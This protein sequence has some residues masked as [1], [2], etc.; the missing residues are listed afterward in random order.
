MSKDETENRLIYELGGGQWNIPALREL[1]ESITKENTRIDDFEVRQS[2]QHIGERIMV[3]NARRIEPN[4]GE[5]LIFL[6]I[7]DVTE[8]W[9]QNDSVRTQGLLLDLAHDAVMVRDLKGTIQYWNRGAEEMYGWKKEEAL[10]KT[11]HET[12]AH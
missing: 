2:F 5:H 1:L 8:K 3:L 10:G 4:A 12:A 6:S 11:T 7:E 9:R